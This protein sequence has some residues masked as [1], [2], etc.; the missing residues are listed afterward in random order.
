MPRSARVDATGQTGSRVR[1]P[2]CPTSSTV[3]GQC[4]PRIRGWAAV[5]HLGDGALTRSRWMDRLLHCTKDGPRG[6]A[7]ATGQ[8]LSRPQPPTRWRHRAIRG[9]TGSRARTRKR[10]WIRSTVTVKRRSRA[11]PK[12]RGCTTVE[13]IPFPA[14]PAWRPQPPDRA[15][16]RAARRDR[17]H[18][19]SDLLGKRQADTPPPRG[20]WRAHASLW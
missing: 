1:L 2:G 3:S 17:Q 14:G 12:G 18:R 8:G 6:A 15:R 9:E 7:H 10:A 5:P 11:W 16:C 13:A 4:T 20:R 19:V